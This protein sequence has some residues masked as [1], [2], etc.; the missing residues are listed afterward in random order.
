MKIATKFLALT[1]VTAFALTSCHKKNN[2][3]P[4]VPPPVASSQWTRLSTLPNENITALEIVNNVIYAGSATARKI[5]LSADNGATWTA[6]AKIEPQILMTVPDVHITAIALFNNKIYAGTDWDIYSIADN[7]T[8]WTDEGT[9]TTQITSFAV[10]NSNLYASSYSNGILKLNANTNKWEPFT[11]GLTTTPYDFDKTATKVLAGGTN[12]FAGTAYSFAAFNTTQ[13][14]WVRKNYFNHTSTNPN[15]WWSD[16]VID[17]VYN[18]GSLLGQ[19]YMEYPTEE[20]IMRSDDLGTTWTRDALDLKTD[21]SKYT[22]HGLL[23]GNTKYYSISNQDT[24]TVGAWIQQRDKSAPA[25]TTWAAGEEFLPALHAWAIR[26][27]NGIL[28]LA[29]DGGLYY[30]RI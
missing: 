30:R 22:M 24:I 7:G 29:T 1:L 26:E 28:F 5:Y 20:V 6:T 2:P 11:N 18:Q 12:L 9:S 4:N 25:G 14:A 17:L 8:A 10:W 23:A 21:L 3:T 19:V 13:Q 16:Y 15:I 27:N